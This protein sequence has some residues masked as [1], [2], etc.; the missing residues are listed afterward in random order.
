MLPCGGHLFA[1]GQCILLLHSYSS[2][3]SKANTTLVAFAGAVAFVSI[4]YMLLAGFKL[5][6]PSSPAGLVPVGLQASSS[7][8]ASAGHVAL[9]DVRILVDGSTLQQHVQFF[10][11]LSQQGKAR[12]YTV[13]RVGLL[14]LLFLHCAI[15]G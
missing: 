1:A 12:I 5:P 10:S 7:A 8:A 11:Q 4:T 14:W 2:S 13:S 9:Q 3:T 6:D 15:S